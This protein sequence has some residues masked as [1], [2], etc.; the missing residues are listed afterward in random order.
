M[1]STAVQD[2][3]VQQLP[4]G[5]GVWQLLSSPSSV[6]EFVIL[7]SRDPLEGLPLLLI[8][9]F[10]RSLPLED[11]SRCYFIHPFNLRCYHMSATGAMSLVLNVST[12]MDRRSIVHSYGKAVSLHHSTSENIPSG[13]QEMLSESIDMSEILGRYRN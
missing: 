13:G 7:L 2:P 5:Q 8:P 1:E 3:Q 9:F 4:S 10:T 12:N 6:S 11:L